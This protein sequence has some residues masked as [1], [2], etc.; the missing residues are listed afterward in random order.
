MSTAGQPQYPDIVMDTPR[1]YQEFAGT[2]TP[3]FDGEGMRKAGE[4]Y[5]AIKAKT[6][7]R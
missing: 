7:A 3:D 5:N 4:E 6:G 1:L 2:L